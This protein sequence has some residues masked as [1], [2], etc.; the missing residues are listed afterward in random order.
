MSHLVSILNYSLKY[1]FISICIKLIF[2]LLALSQFRSVKDK[3]Y[4]N[5]PANNP[6]VLRLNGKNQFGCTCKFFI[7]S[8]NL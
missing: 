7:L 4:V 5:I 8:I 1:N 6:C 3:M 2:C